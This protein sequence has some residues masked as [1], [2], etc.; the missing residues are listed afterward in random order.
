MREIKFRAFHKGK[1]YNVVEIDFACRDITLSTRDDFGAEFTIKFDNVKLMQFTGLKDKNGKEIYEG[2]IIQKYTYLN[3]KKYKYHK[4]FIVE[5]RL[6]PPR[7][8][9]FNITSGDFCEVIGNKFE[10]LQ[11]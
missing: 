9:G 10:G 4:P 6:K 11:K 5:W 7:D 3:N 8:N 2:D 1:I